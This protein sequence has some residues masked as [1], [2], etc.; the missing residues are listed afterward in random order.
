MCFLCK[1]MITLLQLCR[2]TALSFRRNPFLSAGKKLLL[3]PK[4]K[5]C[6]IFWILQPFLKPK[7]SRKNGFGLSIF[8]GTIGKMSFPA[9]SHP[10]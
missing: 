10:L 4:K 7:P 9:Q 8:L 1:Y 6:R 5:G 3:L 2:K